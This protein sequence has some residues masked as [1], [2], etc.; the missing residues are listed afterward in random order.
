MHT[1]GASRDL[2]AAAFHV[3]TPKV[4]EAPRSVSATCEVGYVRASKHCTVR[5]YPTAE[6]MRDATMRRTAALD[7]TGRRQGVGFDPDDPGP[8]TLTRWVILRVSYRD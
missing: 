1:L 2:A 5:Q 6:R 8:N 3:Y 7:K 4:S